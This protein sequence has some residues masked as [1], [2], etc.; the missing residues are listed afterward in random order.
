MQLFVWLGHSVPQLSNLTAATPTH[1]S[2]IPAVS[3]LLGNDEG[4]SLAQRLGATARACF[5]ASLVSTPTASALKTGRPVV[6]SSNLPS[7]SPLLLVRHKL[8]RF[9][10]PAALLTPR[11]RYL[12]AVAEKYLVNVLHAGLSA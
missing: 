8:R 9:A 2:S 3:S 1:L 4:A 12:Q 6:V 7:E 5:A 11:C 10:S